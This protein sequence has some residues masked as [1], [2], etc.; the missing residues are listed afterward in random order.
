MT[1]DEWSKIAQIVEMV[2]V[3]AAA[4]TAYF[5]LHDSKKTRAIGF[6]LP[7][8]NELNSPTS[9]E[10]RKRL[11]EIDS[12]KDVRQLTPDE[13]VVINTV[14]NQ[15][16]FLGFLT[17]QGL[18]EQT[19]VLPLYYGTIIRC[20][21]FSES[22]VLWQRSLRGTNFAEHFENLAEES[23]KYIDAYRH[24]E[25]VLTYREKNKESGS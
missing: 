15:L 10:N 8:F 13:Q 17:K 4:I 5:H 21:E 3:V 16:D 25:V 23:H 7:L 20:W 24:D 1:L 19:L 12:K 2:V 9:V 22:Y 11:Y 6:F 14:V 18:I